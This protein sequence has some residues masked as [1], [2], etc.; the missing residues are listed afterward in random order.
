MIR[1][2]VCALI[3]VMLLV[4]FIVSTIVKRIIKTKLRS[5]QTEYN[6]W[7]D[8]LLAKWFKGDSL[9]AGRR[10]LEEG[11]KYFLL[12]KIMQA[13]SLVLLIITLIVLIFMN[14]AALRQ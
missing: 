14:T 3:L 7:K 4:L 2:I 11:R 9:E 8:N 10:K 13:V 12:V 1:N 6:R 5:G